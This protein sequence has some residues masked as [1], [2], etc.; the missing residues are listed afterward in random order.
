MKRSQTSSSD[1]DQQ[2]S[3]SCHVLIVICIASTLSLFL[4]TIN[5][6][7][8]ISQLSFER[9]GA[10]LATP[11]PAVDWHFSPSSLVTIS[12]RSPRFLFLH[13]RR[14]KRLVVWVN[15]HFTKTYATTLLS[16]HEVK[17]KITLPRFVHF[18]EVKD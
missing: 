12:L 3:W 9:T 6:N 16:P 7:L 1:D 8:K 17:N 5:K 14:L 18:L 2:S 4:K 10:E 15:C 11:K 13:P